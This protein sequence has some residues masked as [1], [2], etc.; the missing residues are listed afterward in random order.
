MGEWADAAFLRLQGQEGKEHAVIQQNAEIRHQIRTNAPH[1]WK[2]LVSEL[3]QEIDDF[4]KKRPDYLEIDDNSDYS[5]PFVTVMSPRISVEV[6]L[7]QRPAVVYSV[8]RRRPDQDDKLEGQGAYKFGVLDDGQV[9]LL[10][11]E[12][13]GRAIS[14][15]KRHILNYLI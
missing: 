2:S 1:V 13:K 14:E 6:S 3:K 10:D 7:D 4:S 15:V 9:W 5:D 8:N 12:R 11:D